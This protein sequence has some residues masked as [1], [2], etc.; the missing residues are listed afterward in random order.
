VRNSR[1]VV[2]AAALIASFVAGCS[3]GET[4]GTERTSPIEVYRFAFA[5]TDLHVR[6]V[7]HGWL[8]RLSNPSDEPWLAT[9]VLEGV[10]EAIFGPVAQTLGSSPQTVLLPVHQE[11]GVQQAPPSLRLEPG[12]AGV[13]LVKV[14]EY[15]DAADALAGFR[16]LSAPVAQSDGLIL[17]DAV[18]WPIERIEAQQ[19]V[20]PGDHV[21]T[22]TVGVW[23]N[24]TAFY[25]NSAELLSDP[26]LPAGFDRTAFA[27]D[28]LPVYV[29]DRGR[30]EQPA[31]SQDA[32]RATTID[33]YNALL[34]E[35]AEHSTGVRLIRPEDGYT[36]PE[37]EAHPL[38]GEPLI[39][40]NTV[41]V[42]DGATGPLDL[43]PDPTGPCFMDRLQDLPPVAAR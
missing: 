11:G 16:V 27:A 34:K 40:L 25:T 21:Q 32:C 43:V 38:Y 17:S 4:S 29:Y 36:T 41:I 10:E 18:L 5:G 1:V 37:N 12:G 31:A 2:V 24:G 30:D 22:V 23:T 28:P 39:F 14:K 8:L 19:P 13:F 9:L 7:E 6:G 3:E 42:H 15:A 26:A 20:V 35:Q 33:G